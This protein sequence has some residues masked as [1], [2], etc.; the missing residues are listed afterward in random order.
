MVGSGLGFT[1]ADPLQLPPR[2]SPP[3]AK[4]LFLV[5]LFGQLSA[6]ANFS[7]PLSFLLDSITLLVFRYAWASIEP[8]V[9]IC[10]R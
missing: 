5:F 3:S 4:S 6:I 9:E 10:Y 8:N 7:G 1:V 2:R